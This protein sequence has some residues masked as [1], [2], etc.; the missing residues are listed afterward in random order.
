MTSLANL[1]K[2]SFSLLALALAGGCA[3]APR[4]LVLGSEVTSAGALLSAHPPEDGK[5]I[6]PYLLGKTAYS[7]RHLVWVRDRESPHTHAVHDLEVVLLRGQGTLWLDGREIPMAEGDVSM[8]PAGTPH[9]FI[10]T[11]STPSAALAVYA[12]PSDGSDVVPY[13][14]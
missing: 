13:S 2:L 5:N 3:G 6:T 9:Y 14:K 11:G 12:P 7:S 10:N 8:I 1:G 4:T